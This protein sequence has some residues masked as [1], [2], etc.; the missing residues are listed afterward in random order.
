M[1]PKT[2]LLLAPLACAATL[3]AA[4]AASAGD[5]ATIWRD[6]R[7]SL[8]RTTEETPL[9]LGGPDECLT[10]AKLAR[11]A[12]LAA[13]RADL[14]LAIASCIN[15]ESG[16]PQ[17]FQACL[18]EAFA[19]FHAALIEL[20][21]VHQARLD[22]CA[23]TGGGIYDPDLDED[24][25]VDGVDHPFL[26]FLPGATWVYEKDTD[27]GL[28]QV[29]VTVLDETKCIDDIEC[30]VVRDVVTLD[31]VL[32]EDT[33]DWYAQH[34]DG[35]VWYMGEIAQNYDDDGDL[36]DVE[37][38]WRAGEDGGLPGIV[39]PAQPQV[40]TT[41]RQELLLTEAEDAG[42]VLAV[43]AT[44]TI[45]LGTFTGCLMTADFTPLEPGVV[46]HKFYAPGIGLILEVDP[47]TGEQLE[48]VSF[49]PGS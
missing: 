39:M 20:E 33:L 8:Q 27:E 35:T 11:G 2:L 42:T 43:D 16:D 34:E 18:A 10:V 12:S 7:Q 15:E 6:A 37:G 9:D 22:L 48:L 19:D 1:A 5:P 24:E 4:D 41:Y 36:I 30:I 28:E 38:S 23:L 40:G 44:V 45:D 32:V 3:I 26:P 31:G 46:E 25:F 47:D 13:L 14:G 21:H 29:T 17:K 49:T